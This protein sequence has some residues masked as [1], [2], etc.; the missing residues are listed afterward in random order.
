MSRREDLTGRR[1]GRLTFMEY[2]GKAS[3]GHSL[4]LCKCDCGNSKLVNVSDV[5]TGKVSSCGCYQREKQ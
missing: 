3:N 5:K 2:Y 1:F 4:W